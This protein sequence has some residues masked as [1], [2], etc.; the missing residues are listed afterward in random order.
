MP[1]PF[2]FYFEKMS[3]NKTLHMTLHN[4]YIRLCYKRAL[5]NYMYIIQN[6]V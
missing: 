3:K 5:F 6:Y 1:P 2:V 4:D